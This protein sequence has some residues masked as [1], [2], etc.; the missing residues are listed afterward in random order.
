MDVQPLGSCEDDG[1]SWTLGLEGGD[2]NLA[3]KLHLVQDSTLCLNVDEVETVS[4]GSCDAGTKF[5]LSSEVFAMASA[6]L[7]QDRLDEQLGKSRLKVHG[8]E[9]CI[10]WKRTL[11]EVYNEFT[12]DSVFEPLSF[13]FILLAATPESA[14]TLLNPGAA[15]HTHWKEAFISSS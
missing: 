2:S 3:Y 9:K 4:L 14:P 1:S 8:K 11:G 10:G 15:N 6:E 13:N 12:V 7:S 5:E